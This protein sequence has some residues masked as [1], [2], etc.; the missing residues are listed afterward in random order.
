M[1]GFKSFP[2]KIKLNFEDGITAVVG[3]N[4]SGKSNIS[5]AVRWVLGEQ[6]AK[7][8]R[9]GKMED[10]IFNGT[11]SRH[12]Q[13]FAEVSLTIDNSTRDIAFDSDDITVTRKY[14]RSGDSE[15][16]INGNTVRLKDIYEMFMDTGLGRDGYSLI[17]QGRISEIIGAKSAERREIFE[18]ASGISKYRYR[19][20]EAEK[21][22][23]AAED[24]L[25]RLNDILSELEGRVGPLKEQS[26]KAKKYIEFSSEKKTLEISVWVHQLGLIKEELRDHE[27]RISSVKAEY[28]AVSGDLEGIDRLVE[29]IY[30]KTREIAVSIENLRNEISELEEKS[31]AAASRRA[32]FENDIEH[33][34]LDLERVEAG[35]SA[36]GDKESEIKA[37]IEKEEA[38]KQELTLKKEELERVISELEKTLSSLENKGGEVFREEDELSVRIS[39]IALELSDK[40]VA[41]ASSEAAVGNLTERVTELRSALSQGEENRAVI[42]E[43]KKNCEELLET[44]KEKI[45]EYD[46]AKNGVLS[47]YNMKKNK[48]DALTEE[49]QKLIVK[50]EEKLSKAAILKDLEKN[51]EGFGYS[52]KAIAK[53]AS[54]GG[55]RGI[56]GPVSKIISVPT[57]YTVAIETALAGAI[58]N[59]VTENEDAAKAAIAFLKQTGQGRA[60]F[61]PI[62]SMKPHSI[63][64]SGL[65]KI[66]GFIDTADNLVKFDKKYDNVIKNLLG[67]VAVAEDMDAA[68]YIAKKYS[69]RFKIVTLDGQVINAGGSF[70]GG[71]VSKSSGILSRG[72]EIEKLIKEA[73]EFKKKASGYDGDIEALTEEV[74]SFD[75]KL[76]AIQSEQ[77]TFTED[78]I[79][80]GAEDKRLSLQLQSFDEQIENLKNDIEK[81]CQAISLHELNITE[82][83][84]A[85]LAL[86]EEKAKSEERLSELGAEKGAYASEREELTEKVVSEKMAVL[87]ITKDLESVTV[88]IERLSQEISAESGVNSDLLAEKE[89]ILGDIEAKKAI[90]AEIEK[91]K[92]EMLSLIETKKAEIT[93]LNETRNNEEKRITE[94]RA[95]EKEKIN[96]REELSTSMAR[97]EERKNSK[98]TEYDNIIAKL[99]NEYELTKSEAAEAATELE[100]I[101]QANKRLSELRG[102]IRALG[103]VNVDAIAEY[104]EVSE[105]YT[106]MKAQVEDIEKSRNELNR[107]ISELTRDMSKIFLEN[108]DR[109]NKYFGKIFTELFGGGTA[110]LELSD[111]EDVLSSGIEIIASPPGKIIKNLSSL[112]GGE[113]ALVAIAIY[114]AIMMVKPSPFCILDEIEAALDDVNVTKYAQYLRKMCKNTQFIAITHRRGTMEEADVL[115]GVTMQEEGVSK[116]LELRVSEIEQKLGMK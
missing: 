80:Y 19:K 23:A 78:E 62:T 47:L 37:Q 71:S 39:K 5:D 84:K 76:L 11:K 95:G 29:E 97:M 83:K 48:L 93:T 44:L 4:G 16:R 72:A 30:E 65:Q 41:I 36:S 20:E 38:H 55:L 74:S 53:R 70:T 35:L 46:N 27:N 45:A 13:S 59:I 73:E 103:S 34:G 111:R 94:I 56:H 89:K 8:L 90:I 28:D 32:V 75:A 101:S 12:S 109:I 57:E 18:E 106:F 60:T 1:Q 100:S 50:A 88:T 43:E 33:A 51:M 116:L 92:A 102:K 22:L 99:W 79:R 2:D 86:E 113:Q 98:Q 3:P 25:V 115:Y 52:I 42:E 7:T 10:V 58:Q 105:R 9:G 14:Y 110:T 112:S 69:Y 67:R 6:S 104:E 21:K 107:L 54:E 24:N 82:S 91:E 17:G 31:S 15:Y 40:A 108:F 87:E 114:F 66:E 81:N 68:A 26:E 63:E 96:K 49:K 85:V 77:Q 64:E 61:L